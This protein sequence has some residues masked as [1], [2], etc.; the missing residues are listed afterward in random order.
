MHHP[1]AS[2]APVTEIPCDRRDLSPTDRL[3]PF[4][5]VG[6]RASDDGPVAPSTCEPIGDGTDPGLEPYR[7]L[8]LRKDL[9]RLT[10]FVAEGDKVVDRLLESAYPVESL[11][12][13]VAAFARVQHLVER[14][15]EPIRVFLATSKDE[16]HRV[17]GFQSEDL[18]AVGRIPRPTTLDDV[19]GRTVAPRTFAALDGVT[20]AENVGVV[21]RNAAGLGVHALLVADTTCSPYLTRAIRTSMGAVFRLLVVEGLP[22]AETLRRLRVRGVRSVAAHPTATGRS[23]AEV[24]FRGDVCIVL[25]SE[26]DG[27]SPEVLAAC[28]VQASIRMS[29]GVDSLNVGS[30]AAAFFYEASRQRRGDGHFKTT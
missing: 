8:R 28:D 6:T 26:G 5:C 10:R 22:L 7:T 1:R 29:A 13:T 25:G 11:L 14:R 27:I 23:L 4:L 12:A 15:P 16:I 18:K 2:G 21:V 24:D 20:N 3:P 30:A 17:T 19:M 9:G